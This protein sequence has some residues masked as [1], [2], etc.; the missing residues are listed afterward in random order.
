MEGASAVSFILAGAEF[1]VVCEMKYVFSLNGRDANDDSDDSAA[2][3]GDDDTE[4]MIIKT[5]TTMVKTT[6]CIVNEII[7]RNT[8]LLGIRHVFRKAVTEWT[9]LE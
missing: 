8:L 4:M 6:T 7:I 9:K 3:T 2:A 1:S 5:S